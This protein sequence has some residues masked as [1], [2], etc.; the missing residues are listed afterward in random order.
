MAAQ[1]DSNSRTDDINLT[2]PSFFGGNDPHTIWRRW[3]TEEPVRWTQGRLRHGFWSVTRHAD[4][5]FVLMND[6]RIFS[7]QRHG[8]NLPAGPEFE[9]PEDALFTE[10]SHSGAQLAI[11]DGQPHTD[12]RRQ[13]WNFFSPGGVRDLD[14]M[15]RRITNNLL[16]DLLE[17]GSCDFT[18]DFAGKVP[19]AVIAAILGI[20]E[21][22]W[23]DL[24][25]WNNMLAAP[26]DPEFAMGDALATQTEGVSNIMRTCIDLAASKRGKG[27]ADLLTALTTAEIDGRPLS[28]TEIGFN[29]L[30]FFAA[31]HET[32][33]ASMSTG[34]VELMAAPDQWR[35]L[36]DHRQDREVLRRAGEE[37]VRYSSPLTHTLRT[38]TEDTEIGGQRIAEG[39]RVVLWFHGANRDP[40]V[41]TDPER[42]DVTRQKNEHLGFAVGKHFCL[43]MHLARLDMAVMLGAML[44]HLE[45]VEPAGPVE[46]ASSNLFWGIKHLPIRFRAKSGKALRE[47]GT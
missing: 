16:A 22:H 23:A 47:E 17:Q 8:A 13:F 34:L 46:M 20:P 5:R 15:V 28:D 25:R 45:D 41:F 40:A 12:L 44:E 31:G 18:T 24:Y 33:R 30:M 7:V 1:P 35:H 19:T 27:G 3:R 43:G 39:D 2:T 9:A 38:A 36:R 37:C 6:T 14:A 11:M 10:L 26:E 21:S 32:T 29:G 42:F 4:M